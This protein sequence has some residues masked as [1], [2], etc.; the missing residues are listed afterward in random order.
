MASRVTLEVLDAALPRGLPA[1]ATVVLAADALEDAKLAAFEKGYQAGWDD[2]TA[3]QQEDDARLRRQVEQNLQALSFTFHE[4]KAHVL[5]GLGPLIEQMCARILPETA[6][7]ALGGL[8][9]EALAPLAAEAAERPITIRVH[10]SA[11]RTVALT[12]ASMVAP[13]HEIVED[14]TLAPGEVLLGFDGGERRI[15]IDAATVAI[16]RAVTAHFQQEQELKAHG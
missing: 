5:R 7:A 9:A 1:D 11:R 14:G 2:A 16:R 8:V 12:L 13:P 15:D 3:A 10:P 4:A 6:R